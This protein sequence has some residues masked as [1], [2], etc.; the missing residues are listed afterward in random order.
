M[1]VRDRNPVTV[2]DKPQVCFSTTGRSLSGKVELVDSLDRSPEC[3][4]LPVEGVAHVHCDR[5]V[6]DAVHL[7]CDACGDGGE[8]VNLSFDH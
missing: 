5:A 2:D 1:G 6:L 8:E 4:G 3:G 7:A